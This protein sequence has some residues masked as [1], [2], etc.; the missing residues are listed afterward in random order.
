MAVPLLYEIDFI[1]IKYAK[2]RA[3]NFIVGNIYNFVYFIFLSKYI[4]PNINHLEKLW[5]RE[6]GDFQVWV[7]LIVMYVLAAGAPNY[8]SNLILFTKEVQF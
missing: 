5:S 3:L 4:L 1:V 8:V 7:N 6:Q 2:W